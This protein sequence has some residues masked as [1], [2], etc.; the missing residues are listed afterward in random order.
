MPM[1][2]DSGVTLTEFWLTSMCAL[3]PSWPLSAMLRSWRMSSDGK[4][5][6][7]TPVP[8]CWL[9]QFDVPEIEMRS[10]PDTLSDGPPAPTKNCT[11]LGSVI[12]AWNSSGPFLPLSWRSVGV[13]AMRRRDSLTHVRRKLSAVRDLA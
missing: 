3:S 9:S 1:R 8:D 13:L 12:G 11:G 4:S 5:D 6:G 7:F 2:F 10:D